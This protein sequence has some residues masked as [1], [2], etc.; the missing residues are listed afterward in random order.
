[1]HGGGKREGV[2]S[3]SSKHG[4]RTRYSVVETW[5]FSAKGT[6]GV[7]KHINWLVLSFSSVYFRL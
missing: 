3:P 6:M 4:H 1:M 2:E 5:Q 7:V